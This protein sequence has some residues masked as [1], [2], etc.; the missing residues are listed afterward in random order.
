MTTWAMQ[1][2]FTGGWVAVDAPTAV[3][4][5]KHDFNVRLTDTDWLLS[6]GWKHEG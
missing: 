6:E 5:I 1:I 4:A 2:G 3:D